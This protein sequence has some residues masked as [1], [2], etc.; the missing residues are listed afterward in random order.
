MECEHLKSHY[1][2][3]ECLNLRGVKGG[4]EQTSLIRQKA[5]AVVN[6]ERNTLFGGL[7]ELERRH[8]FDWNSTHFHRLLVSDRGKISQG[9]TFC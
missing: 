6:E 9:K 3:C 1:L 8:G 4:S 7:V 2:K 5:K